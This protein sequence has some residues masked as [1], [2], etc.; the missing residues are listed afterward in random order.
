MAAASVNHWPEPK[1]AKAFWSQHDL[2]PYQELLR[3]T[4]AWLEP[5][6]G[7][8]W[9]DLGCGG[10]RL[11][12][13]LWEAADGQLDRLVA[14]DCAAVNADAYARLRADL[15]IAEERLRFIPADFSHGLPFAADTSFDGVVSG[16]AIQYAEH[17]SA[18]DDRW[19]TKNYDRL[20]HEVNRVL[21]PGG[22][23]VFSVN[24]PEPKWGKVALFS[25]FDVFSVRKPLQYLKNAWAMWHYGRWLK[26]EARTGRFHY[27]PSQDIMTRLQAA[28][29]TNIEVRRSYA[30]QAYI[31]RARKPA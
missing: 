2:A 6:P 21:V 15:G 7:E 9:L 11:S 4:V 23:F 14:S 13:A 8:R 5:E 24:V 22:R 18:R 31:F 17:Y 12:R 25:L 1:C 3:D 30:R 27:L 10:G 29:F 28:G 19:T 26:R 20:L 16:L